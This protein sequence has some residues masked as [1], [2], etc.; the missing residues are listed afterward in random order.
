MV[1]DLGIG[2]GLASVTIAI[3]ERKKEQKKEKGRVLR[4][5]GDFIQVQCEPLGNIVT[6]PATREIEWMMP[7]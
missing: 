6:N 4:T 7:L 3:T 5:I 1:A 2:R